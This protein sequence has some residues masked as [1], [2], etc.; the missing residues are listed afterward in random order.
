[1]SRPERLFR[2][3]NALRVLPKPVTAARLAIETEVSE[4]TL[5][6]DIASLRASGA[7]IDGAAGVG[8]T[9]TEDP[10]LP[11][12]TFDRIEMEALVVG[13]SDVRQRGDAQLAKAAESALAKIAA[14]LP[15][16]LQRQIL[17]A[18]H[19]VYRYQ[20]PPN[21]APDISQIRTA[22]WEET[23]IDLRYRDVDGALTD[24]RVYPLAIVYLD[25]GP[26]LLAWCCLRKDFRKF[27]MSRM[28]SAEPADESFRPNR[29][30][31]LRDYISQMSEESLNQMSVP[32]QGGQ[33][34]DV[35]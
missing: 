17:H 5:Y 14:T 13:L 32:K 34:N 4:R 24:R 19:M 33:I 1:M 27:L 7:L 16:R 29:V 15:E 25:R 6:R 8:Y 26:G 12:Q 18:T 2:L 21:V 10:A 28:E 35:W 3:M 20:V 31:L 22:S 30:R 9:L 11:P 23:A